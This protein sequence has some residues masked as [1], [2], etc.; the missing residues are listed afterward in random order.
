M[1]QALFTPPRLVLYAVLLSPVTAYLVLALAWPSSNAEFPSDSLL[2]FAGHLYF[3]VALASILSFVAP[4][5]QPLVALGHVALFAALYVTFK[6]LGEW[7]RALAV[8]VI[9]TAWNIY[10]GWVMGNYVGTG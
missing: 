9:A 10:A 1:L 2:G 4:F 8:L 7:R 5:Y 6:H 3:S